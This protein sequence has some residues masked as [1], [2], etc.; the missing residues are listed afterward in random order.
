ML[1]AGQIAVCDIFILFFSW[2]VFLA[3]LSPLCLSTLS[4]DSGGHWRAG[5][6]RLQVRLHIQRFA[7]SFFFFRSVCLLACCRSLTR[8]RDCMR[9]RAAYSAGCA[10]GRRLRWTIF[11]SRGSSPRTRLRRTCRRAGW[12]THT[13]THIHTCGFRPLASCA[14]VFFFIFSSCVRVFGWTTTW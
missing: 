12:G 10:N 14:L 13:N 2:P 3:L 4:A 6:F 11:G 8:L 9:T 1:D 7:D 5:K